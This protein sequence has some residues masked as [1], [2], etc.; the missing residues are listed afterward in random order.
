MI[1][2]T[3]LN[4]IRASFFQFLWI[5][6]LISF[7]LFFLNI[8][9]S[10]SFWISSFSADVQERLWIYFYIQDPE[11]LEESDEITSKIID[12]RSELEKKWLTVNYYSKEDAISTLQARMPEITENFEQYWIE[13][14][15]PPTLHVLFT[16]EEQY[17][18]MKSTIAHY[19]DVIVNIDNVMQWQT[20]EQQ[21]ERIAS[22][23]NFSNFAILF[24]Y[25]IIAVLIVIIITFLMFVIKWSF[26]NFKN[27]IQVEKLLW[28]QFWQIKSPFFLKILGILLFGF[29]F[30]IIY[31]VSFI[32][33][34]DWYMYDLFGIT[35]LDYI[36][37]HGADLAYLI[38]GQFLIIL[39]LSIL[40]SNFSLNRLIKKI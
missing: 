31:V 30:M 21:Q 28:A 26:Y 24:S 9:V 4:L 19:D 5:A 35:F 39:F 11:D 27:Q 32:S 34:L 33:Y 7:L 29:V 37:G 38:I 17:K 13:N 3:F 18:H 25:F 23:I 1:I 2:K 16:N 14:P 8:L 10:S 22:I 15:L 40:I 20:F 12:L 36:S 6:L